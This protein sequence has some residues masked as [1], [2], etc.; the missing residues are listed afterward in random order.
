MGFP[1]VNPSYVLGRQFPLRQFP[2]TLWIKR[3]LS[4][5]PSFSDE[6]DLPILRDRILTEIQN[7]V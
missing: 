7:T 1:L 3:H 2:S 4:C 5:R 6:T